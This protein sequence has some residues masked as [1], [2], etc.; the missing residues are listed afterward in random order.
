MVVAGNPYGPTHQY[1]GNHHA[2]GGI[3]RNNF[4]LRGA[5]IALELCKTKDLKV[6][7]NSIYSADA[8]Y[9][10]TVHIYDASGETTNL[11][12]AYNIIRGQIFENAT[13]DWTYTGNITGSTPQPEWF[14]DPAVADLHLTASATAAIDAASPLPEVPDDY[15][16]Q[17]RGS[18]PD[19]GADESNPPGPA[20]FA[21][22]FESGGFATGGWT[23]S[24]SASVSGQAAYS[25]DYGAKLAKVAS[26]TKA[27][28]TAGYGS[29]HVRFYRTTKAL[30]AGEYLFCEWS[31]NGGQT[32]YELGKT[33]DTS[34]AQED[35]TC[36][37]GADN[38][39]DFQFR[40]RTNGNKTN[41][42]GLVDEVEV[43]GTPQ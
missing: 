16:L 4:V 2:V 25:G 43:T 29:I 40:F 37:A 18:A 39:P 23:A 13:G 10:R 31:D 33:Q 11:H 27:L 35:F 34:W 36:P 38:N 22:G 3:I 41:E 15:D 28:S 17:P 32:W 6:Y 7:Y 5:Y 26:I 12:L 14:V 9:F 24:G 20:L 8:S 1:A 19:V 21:D 42:Q 30:D